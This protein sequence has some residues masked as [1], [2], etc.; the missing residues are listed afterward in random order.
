MY[1]G[2]AAVIEDAA[3]KGGAAR[4]GAAQA[5]RHVRLPFGWKVEKRCLPTDRLP[6]PK[7][8]WPATTFWNARTSTK[9]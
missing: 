7:S 1:R 4:L 2:H 6:R 5:G 9:R 3:R 8:S